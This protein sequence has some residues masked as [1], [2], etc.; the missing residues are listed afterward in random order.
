MPKAAIRVE[1]AGIGGETADATLDRLATALSSRAYDLVIWQVGTNDALKGADETAFRARVQRGIDLAR[2]AK[3][4]LVIVDQ[5]LFPGIKDMKR[6]ER[7]VRAVADT[8]DAGRVPVFSRFGMMTAW[9]AE[10]SQRL[11]AALSPDQ[12]H[13]NDWGYACLARGLA[14]SIQHGLEAAPYA[15]LQDGSAS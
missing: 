8:A 2:E 14:V 7:F 13:M 3:A 6:Y 15:A 5:Q 9:A 11:A 1:N 10:G 12:F 4:P